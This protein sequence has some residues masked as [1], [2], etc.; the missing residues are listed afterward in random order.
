MLSPTGPRGGSR[1]QSMVAKFKDDKIALYKVENDE[2]EELHNMSVRMPDMSVAQIG[3]V[4]LFDQCKK[5]LF[6]SSASKDTFVMLDTEKGKLLN[7]VRMAL[8]KDDQHLQVDTVIPL[9]M[10]Y[11][12]ERVQLIELA[13]LAEKGT[14]CFTIVFDP[15]SRE[16]ADLQVIDSSSYSVYKSVQFT[17]I[18]TAGNSYVATGDTKGNVRLYDDVSGGMK[19]SGAA[20]VLAAE[21]DT[22]PVLDVALRFDASMVVWTTKNGVYASSL[23]DAFWHKGWA[24]KKLQKPPVIK[25]TAAGVEKHVIQTPAR[26]DANAAWNAVDHADKKEDTVFGYFGP[27]A[28]TWKVKDIEALSEKVSEG[29]AEAVLKGKVENVGGVGRFTSVSDHA[30]VF[31]A[32]GAVDVITSSFDSV[33]KVHHG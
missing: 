22:T 29:T 24:Q 11:Q 21:D 23:R 4:N 5:T 32:E 28:A 9:R 10:H 1:S 8:E 14:I 33:V 13:G 25:L 6:H 20:M 17:S 3:A 15:R 31:S 30:A 12:F 18:C 16:T 7:L 2:V 27:I 19:K 26:F